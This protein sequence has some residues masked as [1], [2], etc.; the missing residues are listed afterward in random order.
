MKE[1]NHKKLDTAKKKKKAKEKSCTDEANVDKEK[2]S[3]D[4]QQTNDEL[5]Q[6][7]KKYDEEDE[8]VEET[9]DQNGDSNGDLVDKSQKLA[10]V[11]TGY[12]PFGKHKVNASWEAV[13]RLKDLWNE[14]QGNKEV[15][16]ITEEIPVSYDFVQ[17]Q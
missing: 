14:E 5:N 1:D 11:V 3:E 16:L 13:K 7:L 12:G 10:I 2:A 15:T 9:M 17:E 8:K 4:Q 6:L